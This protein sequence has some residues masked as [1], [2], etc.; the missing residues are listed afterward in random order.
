[1]TVKKTVAEPGSRPGHD[2]QPEH[3]RARSARRSAC[4]LPLRAKVTL[5]RGQPNHAALARVAAMRE[6][7]SGCVIA[8]RRAYCTVE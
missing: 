3:A 7:G 2:S 6:R 1:M 5:K 4:A 8:R